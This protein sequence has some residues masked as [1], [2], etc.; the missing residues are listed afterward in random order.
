MSVVS[1]VL[2]IFQVS[3]WGNAEW[4]HVLSIDNSRIPNAFFFYQRKSQR[5]VVWREVHDIHVDIN[6]PKYAFRMGI[7]NARANIRSDWMF[8]E[9]HIAC[10]SQKTRN[11]LYPNVWIDS[12]RSFSHLKTLHPL[13]FSPVLIE[14]E[15][16]NVDNQKIWCDFILVRQL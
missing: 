2:D 7:R 10:L 1:S 6:S 13:E 15:Y 12:T 16:E 14:N 5:L 9:V 8:V 11:E 4:M 3:K